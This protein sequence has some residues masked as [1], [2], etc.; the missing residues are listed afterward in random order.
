MAGSPG[1]FYW[2]PTPIPSILN[3]VVSEEEEASARE[4]VTVVEPARP[5][6]RRPPV[7]L[8]LVAL[9]AVLSLILVLQNT[10]TV[11]T[12]ILFATIAMPRAVLL[13]ITFLLGVVVGLLIPFLRKRSSSR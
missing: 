7:R 8:I 13:A 1:Y 10:D 12:K 3:Q 5:K 2:G 4:D 11:E 6:K 9:V